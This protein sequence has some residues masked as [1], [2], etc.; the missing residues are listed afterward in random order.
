MAEAF[1]YK[2]PTGHTISQNLERIMTV[3]SENGEIEFVDSAGSRKLGPYKVGKTK[4]R[5]VVSNFEVVEALTEIPLEAI[6]D[7]N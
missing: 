6:D 4:I 1:V 5:Y 3:P 2:L 7:E